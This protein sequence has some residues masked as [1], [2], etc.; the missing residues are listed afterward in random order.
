MSEYYERRN[1]MLDTTIKNIVSDCV[2]TCCKNETITK[3]ELEEV[4][5]DSLIRILKSNDL[6][7]EISKKAQQQATLKRRLQGLR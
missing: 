7:D 5:T 1:V 2:N 6:T 4:L 3:S